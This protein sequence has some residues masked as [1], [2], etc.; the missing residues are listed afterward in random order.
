[1]GR[2]YGRYQ[3]THWEQIGGGGG[4]GSGGGIG[5]GHG[6]GIG[7]GNGS[8]AGGGN[9]GGI[10]NA[11]NG[12]TNPIVITMVDPEY[13][14]EARKARFTG[15][16]MLSIVVNASGKAT[17]VQVVKSLGMGLDEKAMEAV[18]KWIFKPGTSKGVPVSVRAQV[19]VTFSLL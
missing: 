11:G 3:E 14:E 8:G 17:D 12:V 5:N 15:Y 1:M 16:V 13:S 9:G 18:R 4:F 6:N 7:N 19:R 10:Y 2:A